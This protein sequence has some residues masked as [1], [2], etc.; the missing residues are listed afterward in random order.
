MEKKINFLK[1]IRSDINLKINIIL[2]RLENI[3]NLK[4][5]IITSRALAHL[6]K[7]FSYSQKFNKTNTVLI[8][9][10]GK[11]V[12]EE[13]SEVKKKWK[14]QLENH[15]SLSDSRGRLLVIKKINKI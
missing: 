5:D 15:Q 1:Q 8:F 4:F 3:N 9:L 6:D 7:L 13:L 14:F 10:K 11:T 2:Q 12:N